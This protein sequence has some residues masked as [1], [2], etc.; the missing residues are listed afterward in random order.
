[1]NFHET[2]Y[3]NYTFALFSATRHCPA[4]FRAQRNF[5]GPGLITYR[6]PVGEQKIILNFTL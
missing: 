6:R 1:M 5:H 2:G 3:G 4:Y